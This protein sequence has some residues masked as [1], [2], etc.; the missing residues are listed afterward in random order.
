MVS[1]NLQSPQPIDRVAIT[2]KS[3]NWLALG[4]GVHAIH[5]SG[6][7]TPKLTMAHQSEFDIICDYFQIYALIS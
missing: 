2:L 1:Y 3:A 4:R 7:S 6:V 5:V